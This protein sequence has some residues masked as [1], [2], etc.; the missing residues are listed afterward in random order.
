VTALDGI[1][2]SFILA[3]TLSFVQEKAG[4]NRCF[5]GTSQL[6][7]RYTERQMQRASEESHAASV[8]LLPA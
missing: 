1:K 2:S 6:L 4:E 7:L 8:H 5:Q 3:R